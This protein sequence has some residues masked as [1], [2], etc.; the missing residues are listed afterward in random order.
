MLQDQQK[1]KTAKAS[2]SISVPATA[3]SSSEPS[4]IC[5]PAAAQRTRGSVEQEGPADGSQQWSRL[6]ILS[7]TAVTCITLESLPVL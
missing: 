1:N 5:S 2:I 3:P 6:N 4:A 7:C